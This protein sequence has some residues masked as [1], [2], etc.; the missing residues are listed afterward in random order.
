MIKAEVNLVG[1]VRQAAQVKQNTQGAYYY[2]SSVCTSVPKQEGGFQEVYVNIK[3]PHGA[4]AGLEQLVPDQHVSLK[5]VLSFRKDG[6]NIYFNMNVTECKPVDPVLTDGIVGE[7]SMIGVLGSKAPEVRNG[8]NGKPFMNFSAY[9][10]DWDGENRVYTWVRFTRFSDVIEPFL[11]P[12]ALV[13][14]KGALEL[15]YYQNKLSIKCRLAEVKPY[16]KK[17]ASPSE[18][19]QAPDD[20]PF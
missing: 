1:T 14:A 17:G 13:E 12:K 3:A 16:V 8:K 9:S 5:G 20:A 7:L 6:D 19:P 4:S 15:Q 10:G 2:S 11:V 18:P